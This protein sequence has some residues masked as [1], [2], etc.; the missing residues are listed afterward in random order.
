MTTD[1][2]QIKNAKE[3]LLKAVTY[4]EVLEELILTKKVDKEHVQIYWREDVTKFLYRQYQKLEG[5]NY[6]S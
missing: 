3:L 4:S 2:Y 5:F 6:E 1:K